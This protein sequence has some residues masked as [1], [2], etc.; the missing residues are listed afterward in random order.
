MP[1]ML[2]YTVMDGTQFARKKGALLQN[3]CLDVN[4]E[5][6]LLGLRKEKSL[7]APFYFHE[8]FQV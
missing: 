5:V 1:V 7:S 4:L 6:I 2:P 8:K 3:K